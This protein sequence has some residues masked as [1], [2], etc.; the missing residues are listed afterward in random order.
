MQPVITMLQGTW[1]VATSLSHYCQLLQ[2]IADC[3]QLLRDLRGHAARPPHELARVRVEGGGVEDPRPPRLLLRH[4]RG[5]ATPAPRHQQPGG[6]QLGGA[7][8][9]GED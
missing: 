5:L 1:A 6:L 8:V 7:A 9:R 4:A 3:C 2:N